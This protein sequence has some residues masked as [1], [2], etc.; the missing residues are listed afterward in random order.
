MVAE[1]QPGTQYN[2]GDVVQYNGRRYKIIQPHF[3]QGDWTPDITPALW[4][5][6]PSD[7]CGDD[8]TAPPPA[9]NWD[10]HQVQQTPIQ[11]Q[12][13]KQHWYDVDDKRKKELEVGGG[14]AL[15]L[16]A[17]AGGYFAYEHHEKTTEDQK[18]AVVWGLQNWL[19]D[20]QT[21]TEQYYQNGP[22]DAVS[23]VLVHGTQIP[24]GALCAGE[25]S[26]NTLYVAR[27]FHE[28]GIQVGKCAKSFSKGAV[29]GYSHKEVELDTYE[30]LVADESAIRW[31][32]ARG[33]FN[34]SNID[35]EP[36][37][38]GRE[39]DGTVLYVAQ[40]PVRDGTHVGKISEKL[41]AALIA[42]NGTEVEVE[43]YRVLVYA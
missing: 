37:E 21:R 30:V 19:H 26:G 34:K 31:S 3:S 22:T 11:P 18:K 5:L 33:H 38:A 12:E 40:G 23:W 7:Q 20:A 1:W 41:S 6:I 28:G 24:D 43:T 42:A 27:A 36:V 35:G 25:A 9:D 4:G 16:A 8:Y 29:I 13:R 39:A 15:G 2:L 17:I 14:L 32:Q 10:G